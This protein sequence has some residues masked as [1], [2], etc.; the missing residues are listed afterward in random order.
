MRA[1]ANLLNLQIDVATSPALRGDSEKP[2]GGG[3]RQSNQAAKGD[4]KQSAPTCM[5]AVNLESGGMEQT[6]EYKGS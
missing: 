2:S 6:S 4:R 3:D 5:G 1:L